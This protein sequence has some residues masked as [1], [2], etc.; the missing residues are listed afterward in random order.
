M[1]DDFYSDVA[2]QR[3]NEIAAAR[4]QATADLEQA[5]ASFDTEAATAAVQT[6]ADLDAQRTNLAALYNSYVAS[7]TPPQPRE[8]SREERAARPW[9]NMDWQDVVEMTRGS[10]YARDIRPDD[11]NLIAGWQEAQRRKARGE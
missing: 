9:Q 8:V 11:P 5:K 2:R 7:Q 4:A 3:F 10:K 1:A 6:I